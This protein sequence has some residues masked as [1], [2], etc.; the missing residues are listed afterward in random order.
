MIPKAYNKNDGYHINGDIYNQSI[1]YDIEY[2]SYLRDELKGYKGDYKISNSLKDEIYDIKNAYG[3]D[4]NIN[5]FFRK[6]SEQLYGNRLTSVPTY[7]YNSKGAIN[8]MHLYEDKYE[9]DVKYLMECGLFDGLLTR[10]GNIM[11]GMVEAINMTSISIKDASETEVKSVEAG[12]INGFDKE[13][14]YEDRADE[15][16]S[17]NED[18][19]N[20][21]KDV[22]SAI[23]KSAAFYVNNVATYQSELKT[24]G[25]EKRARETNIARESL[26]PYLNIISDTPNNTQILE[27]NKILYTFTDSNSKATPSESIFIDNIKNRKMIPNTNSNNDIY[28]NGGHLWYKWI[29]KINHSIEG[30]KLSEISY[31]RD[32]CSG[33]AKLVTILS[34]DGK[35]I[36]IYDSEHLMI[37][38]DPVSDSLLNN[39]YEMY[40]LQSTGED[41][42]KWKKVSKVNGTIDILNH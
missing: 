36:N 26:K 19:T 9:Y 30:A 1:R 21:F 25:T 29:D 24:G 14:H 4:N 7:I 35:N 2:R 8:Y 13:D 27:D 20:K 3:N 18:S 38:T 41:F 40:V 12:E 31:T 23:E 34:N 37:Y 28:S 6:I 42:G 22:V 10:V 15:V 16:N 32:D 33:F 5:E 11:Y 39:G 17:D